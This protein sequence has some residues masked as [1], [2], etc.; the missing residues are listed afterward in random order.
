[1]PSD[2]PLP[3]LKPVLLETSLVP[4]KLAQFEQL[5]TEVIVNSLTPGQSHCLK[6][7]PGGTIIDGHHRIHVLRKRGIDVDSLAREILIK[8][9]L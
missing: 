1:M 2:R 3:P 7:R 8:E 5:S 6:T 9:N 4:S